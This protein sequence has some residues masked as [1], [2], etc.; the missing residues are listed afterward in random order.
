MINKLTSA[1]I[2]ALLKIDSEVS[3]FDRLESTNLTAKLKA[4]EGANEG[5]LIIALSQTGGRGRLGRSFYSPEGTGVYFSIVLRPEIK[6]E[7]ISLITPV[8]AVAVANAIEAL[9][10]K[11]PKIKWVNDIFVNGKKVC[12]ILSEA[13]FNSKGYAEYVILGIGINLLA[14]KG[15]FPEDIKNIAGG[16]ADKDENLNANELVATVINNFFELYKNLKARDT[17][18]EYQKRMLLVGENINYI[19]NGEQKSGTVEGID[20]AYRLIIKNKNG[21]LTHLQSGEVTIAKAF[22]LEPALNGCF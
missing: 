12:G 16:L 22:K 15:G 20:E 4:A 14:P 11:S 8:A 6:V 10:K 3:V 21:D 13:A 17:V 9:T 19:Q 2:K 1:E 7:E 5:D 18:T